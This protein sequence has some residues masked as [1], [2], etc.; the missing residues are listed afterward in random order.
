MDDN[1][2]GIPKIRT[3]KSDAEIFMKDKKISSLDIASQSY[4]LRENKFQKTGKAFGVKKIIIICFAALAIS[5]GI[6]LYANYFL[7]GKITAP[8]PT[9]PVKTFKPF[10]A[11]EAQKS[12]TF[13]K[14]NPGSLTDSLK[15]E[16]GKN[17]PG[18]TIVYFNTSLTSLEFMNFMGWNPPK[19]FL[20]NVE[21]NFNILGVYTEN[22][23]DIAVVFEIQD[24]EKGLL[25][26]LEWEPAM[27]RDWKQFL[28]DNDVLNIPEFSFKDEVVQNQDARILKNNRAI[29]GYAIFNKKFLVISTSRE[30]LGFVLKRLISLP[31]K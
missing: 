11:V 12:L 13:Q 29:L 10:V 9:A 3:Y 14:I 7:A 23:S 31:P 25:S 18:D 20:E 17:F 5:A 15:N 21:P 6:Y 27:W 30:S 22:K 8:S 2:N 4:I 28:S 1:E 16:L 24:F 19:S 26:T